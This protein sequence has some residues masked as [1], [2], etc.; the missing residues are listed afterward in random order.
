MTP[1]I[2]VFDAYGTLFDVNAAARR[3][4]TGA[5]WADAWPALAALWRAKQLE[6]S[7]L[8]AITGDHADFWQVTQDGLDHAL[9]TLGI[10]APRDTLLALYRQ[11][12]AYAEV[13]GVLAAL[14]ARGLQTAI[15]SNG[16][17]DML[18]DAVDHA[19]LGG[20]L[21]AVLSVEEVGIYKPAPRVYALIEARLGLRPDQA[22]FVSSNGWD[23]AGA[24]RFGLG[25]VWVNRAGA[26]LDRMPGRPAH[27]IPD[28][29]PL[30]GLIA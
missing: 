21:D 11:L 24:A 22:L 20:L 14:R 25:T 4:A 6:Y 3:A 26:A 29:S 16:T 12:D 19:G 9:D 8:R 5:P 13:P 28:L 2:A 18:A 30:P 1:R 27:V 10:A 23:V 7:W 15:L 17:P